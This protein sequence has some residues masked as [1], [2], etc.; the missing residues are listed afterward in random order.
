MKIDTLHLSH[1][2]RVISESKCRNF[3]LMNGMKGGDSQ[4]ITNV[5]NLLQFVGRHGMRVRERKASLMKQFL[6][7]R[8]NPKS[9]ALVSDE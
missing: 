9:R 8:E 1:G 2:A 5:N 7:L 4:I 3:S 6:L